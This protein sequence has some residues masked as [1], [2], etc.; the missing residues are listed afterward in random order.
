MGIREFYERIGESYETAE[1]RLGSEKAVTEFVKKFGKDKTVAEL[2]NSLDEADCSRSFGF[3]HT[4]K[5]V[6][7]ELGFNSLA[8]AA[9]D[10]TEILRRGTLIGADEAFMKTELRYILIEGNIK[11]LDC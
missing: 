4:L 5:G 3:A 10:L 7:A 6:A 2:K 1:K 8:A 11:K 9:S